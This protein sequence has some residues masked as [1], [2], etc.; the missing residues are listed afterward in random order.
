MTIWGM[1]LTLHD[2][3]EWIKSQ[4]VRVS[5]SRE[6]SNGPRGEALLIWEVSVKSPGR[7]AYGEGETMNL[8]L[9]SAIHK[10]ERDI[11]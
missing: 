1:P 2:L 9:L 6:H 4:G 8:A 3:E 11:K 7:Q 10:Y 5:V